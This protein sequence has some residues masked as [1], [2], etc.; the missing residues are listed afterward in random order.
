LFFYHCRCQRD[1]SLDNPGDNLEE[2]CQRDG[3]ADILECSESTW[4]NSE[5]R[6]GIMGGTFNPPHYG[7]LQAAETARECLR[8][9]KVIFVP[10]GKPPHKDSREVAGSEDRYNMVVA[11]IKNNPW[12][13]ASRI[14]I[15][16][17]GPS[18]S[19]DTLREL[20][21][22]Y[23]EKAKFYFIIGSDIVNELTTW[24]EYEKLFRLCEFV[25]V[26][27]PETHMAAIPERSEEIKKL[28]EEGKLK[29]STIRSPLLEISSSDIRERVAQGRSI[30]Y[31]IPPGVK[32][33][34]EKRGLYI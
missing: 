32:D 19:V 5:I 3:S 12:F 6:I 24:K 33:Y 20:K 34:I 10:S 1:G 16:R 27:R 21:K 28:I 17:E 31:I 2:E 13:E 4:D 7:H 8:L 23:G 22:I 26:T 29:I 25:E 18:Y 30:R 9:N 14:E 11:A 15:D